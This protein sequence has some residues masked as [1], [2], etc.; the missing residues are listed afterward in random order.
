MSADPDGPGEHTNDWSVL[1]TPDEETPDGI[2]ARKA[3]EIM[4]QAVGRGEPFFLGVGFRR[5]HAPFA[6]PKKYFDMYPPDSIDLPL[7]VPEGYYEGLP[8]AAINYPAPEKPLSEKEQR[9]LIAAYYACNSFVDA[10]VGV[11]IAAVDRL[12]IADNTI[13][14]FVSDHGYHLGDH[15]GFWHKMSLFEEAARVPLIIYAPGMKA[16]GKEPRNW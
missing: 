4:E 6:A 13:I 15:G 11:V 12:G 14:V 1:K 2:V 8:A 10:Q 16:A 9:E 3:V 7:P 5:P